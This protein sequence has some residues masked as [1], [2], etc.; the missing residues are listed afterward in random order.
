MG[1]K[2]SDYPSKT[3]IHGDDLLDFS[4]TEDSGASYNQSQ[5]VTVDQFMAYINSNISSIYNSDGNINENRILTSNGSFTKW[6]GGD[7]SVQMDNEIDD[8]GFLINASSGSEFGRFGY[9][10]INQSGV[11]SLSDSGG[12]FF[13]VNNGDVRVNTSDFSISGVSNRTG[14]GTITPSLKLHV[15]TTDVND[16]LQVSN[17]AANLAILPLKSSFTQFETSQI[18]YQ[19]VCGTGGKHFR[20]N[21]PVSDNI[22]M[23]LNGSATGF[24]FGSGSGVITH[25]VFTDGANAGMSIFNN[26]SQPTGDLQI[27]G[28]NNT[29]LFYSDASVDSIG[30]GTATPN[31]SAIMEFSSTTKGVRYTPMTA[32]QASAI[33]P[34]EG[35]VVF[36]S[37]TNGTFLSIGL[38]CYE[39]GAWN[40][41]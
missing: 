1:D 26:T 18:G 13:D 31:A 12:V 39:N 20:F 36:T 33:T 37:D 24:D 9:D 6:L 14:V 21:S 29:N 25:R 3:T 30:I 5:K 8:Y 19:F 22:L 27:K 32:T 28:D 7:V 2:I 16:G 11:I 34:Q 41:L 23:Y 4:N 15:H 40:K 17:N 10:Q 35:L 38:H